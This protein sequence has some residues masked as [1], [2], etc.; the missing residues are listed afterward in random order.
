MAW[1]EFHEQAREEIKIQRL[2]DDMNVHYA[3]ACGWMACLW[4]WVA[5]H[6]PNGN[7]ADL[8]AHELASYARCELPAEK[9]STAIKTHGLIDKRGHINQWGRRGVK[10]LLSARSRVQ[11]YRESHPESKRNSNVTETLPSNVTVTPTVPYLTVPNRNNHKDIKDGTDKGL[12]AFMQH[13]TQTLKTKTGQEADA[14]L[15]RKAYGKVV[16]YLKQ[17]PEEQAV[18]SEE[19]DRCPRGM[20]QAYYVAFLCGQIEQRMHEHFK[21]E[22]ERVGKVV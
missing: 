14:K 21:A 4:A 10:Y 17:W 18:I 20:T 11:K 3:E 15:V 13:F 16:G 12:R 2:A 5:G 9:F 7:V 22:A 1:Y 19:V 8:K 6:R